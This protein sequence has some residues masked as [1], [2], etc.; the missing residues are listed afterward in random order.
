METPISRALLSISFG[1]PS[2]G[3]LLPHSPHRAPSERDTLFP[4][5]SFIH[6]SKS[7]VHK[8]PSRFPSG[9]PIE[10]DAC[11]QTLVYISSRVPR[12][13]A[14]SPGSPHRAPSDRD[15]TLLPTGIDTPFPEPSICLSKSLVNK[16][17]PG[18]PTKPPLREMPVSRPFLYI[19]FRAP[20][21][22][23]PP[24][25]SPNRA[26][27]D[28]DALF[29]EPSFN[30]LSQFP[31]NRLPQVPQ[32]GTIEKN[33]NLQNLFLQVSPCYMSSL[34]GSSA[35]PPWREMPISRAFLYIAPTERDAHFQS[36]PAPISH[37]SL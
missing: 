22:G 18:C 12:K 30:Y 26:P 2:K 10:R 29:P 15:A 27:I 28:I 1:V 6:L 16:P 31:V 7:M 13:E 24:P 33:T 17:T 23:A 20:S 32:W 36:S 35:G 21:N 5:P 14:R 19:S 25:G 11:I 34:P 37:S 8:P 4:E 3:A 9:T